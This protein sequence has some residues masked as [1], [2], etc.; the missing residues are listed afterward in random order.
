MREIH[1]RALR[2]FLAPLRES[3]FADGV[4]TRNLVPFKE[5]AAEN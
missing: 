4:V 2:N 1:L 5:L 3:F